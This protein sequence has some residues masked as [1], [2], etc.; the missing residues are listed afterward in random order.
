[1][2]CLSFEITEELREFVLRVM[3]AG[4]NRCHLPLC[5]CQFRHRR[6]TKLSFAIGCIEIKIQRFI[7]RKG[8]VWFSCETS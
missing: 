5:R 7:Q 6:S 4:T 8:L 1:M 3:L 2:V